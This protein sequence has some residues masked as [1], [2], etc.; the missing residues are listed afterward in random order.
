MWAVCKKE[1]R[2]SFSNLTGYIAI[3]VFLLLN[4]LLLFVFPDTDILAGGYATLDKFFELAPWILLL[5]IPAITMRSLSE[6]FRT[7]TFEILQT[8]PLSRTQ[9]V[10]GKYLAALLVVVIALVPTL[11]YFLTIQRLSGQGGIDV[12][13]TIGSYIGL[14]F[15]CAVFTS[16]GMLCSSWT[17]NAVVA[18][19][20]A[21]FACFL[22]YSGF[23][24][25]SQ[26][27]VFAA[28]ADF[29]I[30]ML[31][32]DFHYRS[33]S[34]GVVDSRDLI[35]FLSIILLF[36]RW[37]N[38]NLARKQATSHELRAT[39]GGPNKAL[40]HSSQL[41]ARSS[42]WARSWL[43]VIVVLLLINLG[44]SRFH[45]RLDLTHEKRYTLSISTRELLRHL[46][47]DIQVDF[48]LQ[49]D[50][51]A[52]IRKLS[53][54]TL[55]LLQEFSEYA[56]GRI[57]VRVTDPLAGLD[58][59]ASM[60][61]LDSLQRMGIQPKTQV[62]QSKKGDEQSQR[63]VI[64]G[65]L[66]HYKDKVFP[67]DL[68]KGVQV[69]KQDQPEDQLYTNAETLLEY[70]FG[71]AIDKI[72]RKKVPTVG[73][74]VGNGEPVD[75]SVYNLIEDMR[76]NYRFGI[77]KL[78][79]MPVIPQ[80]VN[81]LI[82]VKPTQKFTD[83]EKL[84]LDQYVLHGGH[85]IW[86][87]DIL[88]AETDSLRL[89]R[90]TLAYDR[91]LE[92]EDLF[93]K[94]GVRVKQDLVEDAGQSASL[95]MV[96]GTIGGKPDMQ[97][98]PWP[99]YPLLNGSLYH[100]IS[101]NLDPV[102][103]R[104]A[105]SIDTVKAP[106]IQKTVLLQTSANGRVVSTPAIISFES[107]KQASDLR[108]FNTPNIPVAYLLEGKFSSLFAGRIGTAVA[109]SLANDYHQPFLSE[110]DKPGRVIVMGDADIVMN[111]VVQQGRQPLQM[112]Y[113]KDINYKFANEDFIENCL[114]YMTNPS[115]ILET[116]SKDFTLRL[117][118]PAKVE[119]GRPFWQFINIGL[120][121][122]LVIAGGYLYQFLRRRKYT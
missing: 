44:A 83:R 80:E 77:I 106:G 90:E 24:A 13:A 46:D 78:D 20:A 69:A 96:V 101:K 15:L 91:G 7:G 38:W 105:N 94:Y 17:S 120:P 55:E 85:I 111:E 11:L 109:D 4:G 99:Y 32:I 48:F 14:V 10:V 97:L 98:I 102:Y 110:G 54:S 60:R 117:L 73:Y 39:R 27:P 66:L 51:K 34:R 57:R 71:S 81:A 82:I 119:T 50:L 63:I 33:I 65:A 115:R 118:D 43:G 74:V 28:G 9:L 36:L 1:L 8:I 31:G 30:E 64:P 75:Y 87:V 84:T 100:P 121:I 103:A 93:F 3:I 112:G 16:I 58:D 42:K 61:T 92:L 22:L 25:V 88:H 40:A 72:T 59:T 49:G 76:S 56:D 116:R 5:L 23:N 18:F 95:N 2:Q 113:S 114:E 41:T 79:S 67:V 52:G 47:D 108:L 26:L 19:I 29:Y 89:D 21:A 53:K 70:K 45:Y 6:E 62:A 107:A 68:L 37:T 35:Y 122:L 104:F 86:A 12:G